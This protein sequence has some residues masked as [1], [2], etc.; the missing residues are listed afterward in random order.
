MTLAHRHLTVRFVVVA[1]MT[2]T[3]LSVG[4]AGA[5]SQS[6]STPVTVVNATVQ[7][8]HTKLGN[9]AYREVGQG[10]ALLLVMGYA[11]TMQTWD[12]H[13]VDML[14]LHYQ[15]I[16]FDNAGID[17]TAP[18]PS[19]LS[20]DKMADQTGALI[21][22]LHLT[23]T[24]V[25]GWSMGSMIAQALAIRHP[26]QVQRLILLAT[27]P[28]TGDAVQ[29]SQKAVN[30][31]TSGNPATSQA[32]LFPKNQVMA[33]DA[34]DGSLLAYPPASFTTAPVIAAQKSAILSWF[35]GHDPS[36][37]KAHQ[38]SVPTLIADGEH[39]HIDAAVN[40]RDV[41]K[42][43]SGSQLVFYP[44][45][46]HAF[47]FQEGESLIFKVRTFL[48]G[49]PTS[50][51]PSQ[52]RQD[53]VSEYKL[54]TAAGVTWVAG[55]KKLT[56]KS[57]AQDL[58]RLDLRLADAEGAF[59]DDL[60]GFGSTGS[61]GSSINTLVSSDELVV[62]DLL[63]FGVQSGTQATKWTTTIQDDGKVVLAAENVV[64]HQ[65]GLSPIKAP[66]ATTTTA[67]S[68]NTSTTTTTTSKF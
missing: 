39:D 56:S 31:L 6:A 68:S 61:L 49:S 64:R 54:V 45:A 41:A 35:N 63:A 13:F 25:L 34:F 10:P 43:I 57:S 15:V 66:P 37:H 21:T 3:M 22:A 2:A 51:S 44:D 28:G 40:D 11:G 33:A 60:L 20:I 47:V 52:M 27:F 12:P 38:I 9:V 29:T 67:P 26:D 46:G 32:V 14:A 7:I 1:M 55:L 30:A 24:D 16:I 17:G 8:A 4:V 19:P 48:S 50:L 36:G 23:H 5:T 53:Y 62:R 18:L 58:G 65:L 42:E 59:D